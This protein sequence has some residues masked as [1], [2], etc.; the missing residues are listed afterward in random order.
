MA[1]ELPRT[2][3]SLTPEYQRGIAAGD[4]EV[5]V[6]DN[7]SPAPVDAA[8]LEGFSG[9]LRGVRIDPAPPTPARAANRR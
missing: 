1:R 6:V 3:R 8:G 7:G 4:Y 5:I 9:A 2:I